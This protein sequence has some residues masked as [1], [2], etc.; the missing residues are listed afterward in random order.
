MAQTKT[1]AD[2]SHQNSLYYKAG[3][4]FDALRMFGLRKTIQKI[5][6]RLW[7]VYKGID[8]STQN[9]HDLTLKGDH[10]DSGTALV[11]TSVDFLQYVLKTLDTVAVQKPEKISFLDYGSG[12]GAAIIFAKKLGFEKSIGIEFAKELHECAL[13]NIE[14]M[15]VTDVMSLHDDA[16]VFMPPLDTTVIFMFNPFDHKVMHKVADNIAKSDFLHNCYIIYVNP[17][18]SDILDQKF[19]L[20]HKESLKSGARV[21]YYK[22]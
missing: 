18:A 2:M 3:E 20:L 12:K 1:N 22:V 10:S 21:H 17:S 11:S 16:A 14:K 19:T 7:Y 4:V 6:L 9:L 8:F 15:G 5:L 13:N